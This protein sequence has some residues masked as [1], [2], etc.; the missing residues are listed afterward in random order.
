MG[1]NGA[2]YQL[3][4][5]FKKFMIQIRGKFSL[6]H[7]SLVFSEASKIN[8]EFL[9]EVRTEFNTREYLCD[10]FPIQKCLK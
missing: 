6:C 4:T 7:L 10:I 2:I 3:F 9:N 8:F 5:E 1:L